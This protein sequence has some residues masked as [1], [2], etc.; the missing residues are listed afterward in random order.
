MAMARGCGAGCRARLMAGVALSLS[1][2][3]VHRR[4]CS[5]GLR[6]GHAGYGPA[7]C[8][9]C[10]YSTRGCEA[11]NVRRRET[12]WLAGIV[13]ATAVLM[14]PYQSVAQ[15]VPPEPSAYEIPSNSKVEFIGGISGWLLSQGQTKWSHDIS[16]L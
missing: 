10:N 2:T 5:R 13:L 14:N 8:R 9:Y 12:V 3:D 16:S 1:P 4:G 15:E 6:T 7:L 11:M